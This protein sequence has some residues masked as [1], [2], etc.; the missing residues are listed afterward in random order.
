MRDV[1][2][3]QIVIDG[4][5]VAVKSSLVFDASSLALTGQQVKQ[6]LQDPVTKSLKVSDVF[7]WDNAIDDVGFE[8]LVDSPLST[9]L[10]VLWMGHNKMTSD[11]LCHLSHRLRDG[12]FRHIRDMFID[13]NQIDDTGVFTLST[14]CGDHGHLPQL[15][16]LGLHTNLI[17][18]LG[19]S[20]IGRALLL[21]TWPHLNTLWLHNNRIE[22]LGSLSAARNQRPSLRVTLHDNP[23][24]MGTLSSS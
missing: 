3:R 9:R 17:T 2:S 21:G 13:D 8:A 7:L 20:H 16:R 5:V 15:R 6:L 12:A 14:A 10:Q 19:A 22:R 23:A 1:F 24:T 18:G 11:A 4:K